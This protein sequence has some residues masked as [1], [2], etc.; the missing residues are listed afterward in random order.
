MT[1]STIKLFPGA[2]IS[3]EAAEEVAHINREAD[4]DWYY[5]VEKDL[6]YWYVEVYDEEGY[7]LGRLGEME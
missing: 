3:F 5:R 2:F 1:T 6:G 4:R 7:P